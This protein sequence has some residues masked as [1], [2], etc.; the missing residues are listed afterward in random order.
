MT[1]ARPPDTETN[2]DV[3]TATK[4]AGSRAD[5]PAET[6]WWKSG[7]IYQIY[8]RSFADS[9]RDGIGDL[10]GVRD[11][12][13]HLEWLGVDGIWLSPVTV[14]PDADWGYD[15]A[16]Y[17][18]V[19]PQFGTLADLDDLIEAAGARGIRVMLDLVPNHTSDRHS[20][21][22]DSRSSRQSARRDW[23]VW[24]DPRPGHA[25]P[26]NWVSSFGGPA[27][28]F[29][30]ATGQY[31]LHNFL[32]EQPDL[33][34][35]NDDVRRAFDDI[36][37]F[38]WDRGVAGFRIDVC[39]MIVK[40]ALLR[41]NPP[42]TEDDPFIMQVFGQRPV[43]N[44]N[45]P[46]VHTILRHWRQ[47]A[48]ERDPQRVLLGETNVE[49]LETLATYYGSGTDELNL[50]FNFPFIESPFE[51]DPL[52]TVVERTESLLPPAAWPVWT[53]SNHDVSRL[54]TRWAA[55][56]PVRVRLALMMLLTMRGTPVLY[57]G[58]EIGL[59]DMDITKDDVHDPVGLR[60][61]PAYKGRDPERTP[62]PWDGSAHSGFTTPD[63]TPWLPLGDP[64]TNVADQRGDPDSIL[65]MARDLIALRRRTRDI[66][67]GDYGSLSAPPGTWV[68]RRGTGIVVALNMSDQQRDVG[69]GDVGLGDVAATVVLG[70]DRS[71]DGT[72]VDGTIKLGP[73]EGVVVSTS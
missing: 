13:D 57:Q 66:L 61:W 32:P 64:P 41:D 65:T 58:D 49:E 62:M 17:Q 35:W 71:R 37:R 45:Q 8:V 53:G 7:V 19:Q 40:D 1:D 27:W 50:G 73:W 26:N 51:A 21:F 12:L 16:D 43:H 28:T 18:A 31:Y 63:A 9:N 29:D 5:T 11:R 20:W 55:G 42:A 14:S 54:A 24:A 23:Y 33:N 30:E 6:P 68:W 25:P 34:W 4:P 10:R 59:T 3:G 2:T 69:L 38:W 39:H 47:V 22:V 60:F 52:R 56:D 67:E 15:V 48:D 46:E 44:A 70:T 36:L 72:T